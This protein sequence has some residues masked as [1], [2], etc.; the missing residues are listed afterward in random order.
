MKQLPRTVEWVGELPGH[1]RL[2]DQTL[3]TQTALFAL[4]VALARLLAGWGVRPAYVAGHSI[5]ELVA[6]HVAGVF[7]LED[8]CRLVAARGRLMGALPAGGAMVSVQASAEELLPML[9]GLEDRVALAAVKKR[10]SPTASS[11]ICFCL[12]GSAPSSGWV[13]ATIHLRRAEVPVRTLP[14][15][16]RASSTRLTRPHRCCCNCWSSM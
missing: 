13:S 7:S 12:N 1:V 15:R 6:A 10:G 14:S 3:F 8:A 4:E 2:L 16:A 9:A 11:M 5:G